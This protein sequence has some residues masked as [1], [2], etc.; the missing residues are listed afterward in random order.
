LADLSRADCQVIHAL[1]GKIGLS[2]TGIFLPDMM[3][4]SVYFQ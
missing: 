4:F 2:A 3:R 1:P